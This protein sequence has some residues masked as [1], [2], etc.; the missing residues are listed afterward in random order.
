[1]KIAEYNQM[2]SYLTRPEPEVLPQ[3]KPPELLDIQEQN[4]KGRLL[5]SLNKIGGGLEDSSLDFINR[6]NFST[7]GLVTKL[8]SQIPVR[9][10]TERIQKI[11]DFTSQKKFMNAFLKYANKKFNGNFSAAAGSIGQDRNKIKAIFDR[12][13]K[14]ETGTRKG[15]I[16][17]GKGDK[18]ITTIPT[19]KNVIPYVDATTKVKTDK[20]F[21]K[22]KINDSNKNKFYSNKD[23][24]NIIGVDVSTKALLDKF[25]SDLKRFKVVNKSTSGKMKSFKLS[26]A[27]NKITKGYENKKVKGQKKS[28]SERL[29]NEAKLD[30]DLQT[31][32]NNFKSTT[33]NISKAENIFIPNAVED[34]GHA[35][36]I[37]ITSKYPKLTKNSNINKI[38]TLTFQDPLINRDILQKTGYEANHDSLLKILNKY[39]NKKIGPKELEELK[40]V[41]S[42]MNTLHNKVL[43]DVKKLAKKNTYLKGQENRVP[44]IDINLPK[45]GQTFKSEDLFVDMSN[46]N[47]AFKVGR[48]EDINPN[49]ESFKDLTREQKEIYKRN[50]LDQTKFNLDK[51]YSKFGFPKEQVNELKDS[52]EFGTAEKLG[53][54]TVGTLGLTGASAKGE[55][56]TTEEVMARKENEGA[57]TDYLPSYGEAAGLTT[58]AAIGSKATKADPLKGLRRF[59]K[60]GAKNLLK[61]IFKVAGA[62]TAAAG[63]AGSEI[64]DYKKPGDAI[65]DI[66]RLDPRNYK[67][68]EDPNI[69]LAGASLL[70]PELVG[71]LAPAGKSIL[72]RAG[73]IFMNPFGKA[74]RAFTPIGL[75][76]IAG[77]A[78]Y[79]VY[80]EIK[81][82]QELTDEERLQE[83]IE[84]QE[85]DD[86]MMVGAAEG[87]RIGFA[88][89]GLSGLQARARQ[90][91]TSEKI[92]NKLLELAKTLESED[93]EYFYEVV[94][95]KTLIKLSADVGTKESTALRNF[96]EENPDLT[97]VDL[98][99]IPLKFNDNTHLKTL[100]E[101]PINSDIKAEIITDSSMT[102]SDLDKIKLTSDKLDVEYDKEKNEIDTNLNFDIGKGDIDFSNTSY[103]N[104]NINTSNLELNYPFKAGNL[105][106]KAQAEDG[107]IGSGE[108]GYQD[109][110]GGMTLYLDKEREPSISAYKDLNNNIML[111]ADL[112]L[113][114][115]DRNQIGVT[116]QPDNNL[117]LFASQDIGEGGTTVGGDYTLFN[118]EDKIG[119]TSRFN[120]SAGADLDG[121]KNA[122]LNYTR[123]FGLK[124][125]GLQFQTN[126]L[127]KAIDFFSSRKNF[128]QSGGRAGF[129][130]GPD[131]PNNP[132]R[133][134]FIKL[135]AGLASL[136]IL[137]KFFKAAEK[138]AP[139]VQQI[140][141]SSTAMPDWFPNFVD[142]FIGR[143]IG[144][145][146]DAD[147][148]EYTNPDLPNIKLSKSDD[149]KILVE[150]T[151]EHNQAYN[152]S[153]EPPGYEVLDYKTGKSVKTS[154]EFEA[155]EGR[156]V[157]LGP[158]DYDT[159][160]FYA[161]DLDELFTSDIAEMEKYTTGNVTK[162]VKDAFGTETGLKKGKYDGDMAQGQAENRA[163]IL[164]DEGLDEID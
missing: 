36:S 107:N 30:L 105:K 57:L 134:K 164:R 163:D 17:I 22:D 93:Q 74:A 60:E 6:E 85:K 161:D 120:I 44:K 15:G 43:A 114:K 48:V 68:Q 49:A 63:F 91:N 69:K 149:G 80:K 144:K 8:L 150:G 98:S 12:V 106:A 116:Y 81:R 88:T 146:I 84:A 42:Q 29:D 117:S 127:D 108:I 24:A 89:G 10:G 11:T 86:E 160:A 32:L 71:S 46:V 153:Y 28:Q 155:V 2:M 66:D 138:A 125:P 97:K 45:Q 9:T 70:A 137:G 159:D 95:P 78:G 79:D 65:L 102:K 147:F 90:E 129:A 141:N 40:S 3:P 35:L 33:R 111:D 38:K 130:D 77:G 16:E 128:F 27:V 54:A 50:V 23:I 26:D 73:S 58:A 61:G 82:R 122:Y 121:E 59:G 56:L 124:D 100:L 157:A 5:D 87:G 145:K 64:L 55:G 109:D 115:E 1:M 133:R 14:A 132:G 139:L 83:D 62:P 19:P 67:I 94:I 34:I 18:I 154:G 53:I 39:V 151:N 47:P 99:N 31:F 75:A 96:L 136:P 13:R 126:N 152:I 72:S 76:T 112:S 51:F 119:N 37:E 158:E 140:K 21:L 135:A 118:T 143:S 110:G 148:M 103:L 20:N 25:T 92:F 156:H 41:K 52:L 101:I 131:D 123:N 142:K 113:D 4:R 162:T 7:A 104:D